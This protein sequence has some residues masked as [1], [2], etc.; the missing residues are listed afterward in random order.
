MKER[1]HLGRTPLGVPARV[2]AAEAL[3]ATSRSTVRWAAGGVGLPTTARLRRADH[4]PA[5]RT[6]RHAAFAWRAYGAQYP[7]IIAML[8][9]D[10][11]RPEGGH[12][13]TRTSPG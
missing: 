5:R 1:V 6:R 4:G 2:K 3:R 10:A 9:R 8:N 13:R 11:P 12:G 7:E